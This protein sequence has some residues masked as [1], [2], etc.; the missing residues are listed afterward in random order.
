M[1]ALLVTVLALGACRRDAPQPQTG[2]RMPRPAEQAVAPRSTGRNLPPRGAARTAAPRD[3]AP[4]QQAGAQSDP[5]P[6]VD[7][8]MAR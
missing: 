3:P 7:A 6:G 1:T 4:L 5:R 2:A 8:M